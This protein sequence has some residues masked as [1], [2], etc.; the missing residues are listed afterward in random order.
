M[1]LLILFAFIA[2]IVTILSPCILPILPIVLSSSAH[3]D[4]MKPWGVVA[5]FVGSFTFFTLFL[6][7]IVRATGIPAD[8]LRL[9]SVI[10]I[11]LFGL[12]LVIPQIQVYF[13]RL[14][15]KFSGSANSRKQR[16]GFVGGLLL[17]LSLGLIWTPCVGP[18]LASVISLALT[19]TVTGSAFVI[20]LAYAIGTAIPM[21][22]I[23]VGGQKAIQKIPQL[24]S[25]TRA[26]Q[27]LFGVLMILTAMAIFFNIDRT[28]QTYILQTF[29]NYGK[30][31]TS[32]EDNERVNQQLKGLGSDT[33]D[34]KDNMGKPMID[35]LENEAQQAPEIIL[36]GEWLNVQGNIGTNNPPQLSDFRGKVVLIDFWTYTCINCIRTLPYLNSW[37]EKYH[38]KGLVII[39]VHTPEFEFEKDVDNL[40]EAMQDYGTEYLVVQD[41]N[42]DTWRAYNNRYW[43]AK[44]LIDKDGRIRYTH[45]GEGKYDETEEMI[46]ELLR[47]TGSAVDEIDVRNQGYDIQSRTPELYLGYLR[48]QFL[49][50]P[51]D[52]KKDIDSKYSFPSNLARN[53]FAYSGQWL[54]ADEYS[55]AR[56]DSKLQLNFESK[57][58]YL[59]MRPEREVGSVTVMLDGELISDSFAG[60]DVSQG[61][62]SVETERLYHLVSLQSAGRHILQLEFSDG[63]IQ[64]FAFTFG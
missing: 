39:G 22:F 61:E 2:G 46:Q 1:I 35:V 60:D 59:V 38:D 20:T 25:K 27:K 7:Q 14:F 43:P 3:T 19:G 45:F 34:Q 47:E 49:Q 56:P 26:I 23:I 48:M 44:Y 54:I 42:Y 36:G 28:F 9:L 63:R 8:S 18:I 50:S 12:S 53:Y 57:D 64:I 58:V 52:V 11:F 5:G 16:P 32:I 6:T 31:L 10:I 55:S 40:R 33:S 15:S 37:H 21:F 24:A 62:V 29:P 51:E 17:G 13:E 41:N 4:E 30:G